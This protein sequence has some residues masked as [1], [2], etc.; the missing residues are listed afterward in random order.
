[1][2]EKKSITGGEFLKLGKELY[3]DFMG[4]TP[5]HHVLIPNELVSDFGKSLS[6]GNHAAMQLNMKKLV[7]M[8]L[9]SM[10]DSFSRFRK[11]TEYELWVKKERRNSA[12][13]KALGW[14]DDIDN[15][16]VI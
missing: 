12:S 4:Q 14:S 13:K 5:K 10:A 6:A 16:Q 7:D 8:A 11:T 15:E 9:L 2:H 1:M 3:R